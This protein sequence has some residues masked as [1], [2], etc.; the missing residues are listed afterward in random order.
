MV[1]RKAGPTTT[2]SPPEGGT[3]K[4]WLF[5]ARRKAEPGNPPWSLDTTTTKYISYKLQISSSLSDGIGN[6]LQLSEAAQ[7]AKEFVSETGVLIV[8]LQTNPLT[9]GTVI[10]EVIS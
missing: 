2:R 4:P 8:S 7:E 6:I 10:Y 3:Y 5:P 9:I 1:R